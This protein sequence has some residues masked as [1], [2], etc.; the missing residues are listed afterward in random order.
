MPWLLWY[1]TCCHWLPFAVR[2]DFQTFKLQPSFEHVTM[3]KLQHVMVENNAVNDWAFNEMTIVVIGNPVQKWRIFEVFLSNTQN[4][5]LK[6]TFLRNYPLKY[7]VLWTITSYDG[8]WQ[9]GFSSAYLETSM[10]QF[11]FTLLY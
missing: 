5:S 7:Q 3:A 6:P 8:P 9:P 1:A 2:V 4:W 10:R 11:S